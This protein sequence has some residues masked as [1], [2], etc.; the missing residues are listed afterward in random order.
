MKK[1]NNLKEMTIIRDVVWDG[2]KNLNNNSYGQK[3]WAII[4]SGE[5]VTIDD[6]ATRFEKTEED[7]RGIVGRMWK[8]GYLIAPIVS[9][10][11]EVIVSP[12][13]KTGK[14]ILK[15]ILEKREYLIAFLRR[16][17]KNSLIPSL[18]KASSAYE[19]GINSFPEMKDSFLEAIKDDKNL[20][21]DIYSKKL[22]K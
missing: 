20:F 5:K 14:L 13:I 6:L 8:R 11:G 2:R 1:K 15:D 7:V 4:V 22:L 17:R 12:S 3:I 18:K 10:N 16:H 9:S 19:S 21:N